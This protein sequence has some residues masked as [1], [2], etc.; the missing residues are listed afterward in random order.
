MPQLRKI[1]IFNCWYDFSNENIPQVNKEDI[2]K[3]LQN[4]AAGSPL[5]VILAEY[6][7]IQRN[8]LE[9]TKMFTCISCFR[10]GPG[11]NMLYIYVTKHFYPGGIK[12]KN[13]GVAAFPYCCGA[14]LSYETTNFTTI[15]SNI[16][17][18]KRKTRTG[19]A[20]FVGCSLSDISSS[21]LKKIVA[22]LKKQ[23]VGFYITDKHLVY[24]QIK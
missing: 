13:L 9:D 3:L 8:V 23:D 5:I 10:N 12:T 4:N 11:G 22:L 18:S 16:M 24:I 7:R 6:Q 19:H 17:E 2:E 20:E 15:Y 14:S 1:G 21:E